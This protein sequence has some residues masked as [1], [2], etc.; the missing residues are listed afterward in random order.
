MEINRIAT[1]QIRRR[2]DDGIIA[3]LS[4]LTADAMPAAADLIARLSRDPDDPAGEGLEPMESG[5]VKV[6][7]TVLAN[8]LKFE[9]FNEAT[10]LLRDILKL[11]GELNRDTQ[12]ELERQIERLFGPQ[13]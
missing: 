6:M 12:A 5:I 11:Q 13:E 7:N 8:M 3:P 2:L 10:A 4:D 1:P 9:G